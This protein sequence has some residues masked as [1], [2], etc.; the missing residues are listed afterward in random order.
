MRQTMTYKEAKEILESSIKSELLCICGALF[1]QNDVDDC[2]FAL[3]MAVHALEKC[4]E[5]EEQ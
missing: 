1:A 3:M 4:A 2:K 5:K